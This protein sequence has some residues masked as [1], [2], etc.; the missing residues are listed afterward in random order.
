MRRQHQSG[1]W[2]ALGV[3]VALPVVASAQTSGIAGVVRDPSGGVLPGVT[4]TVASPALIEQSR[5]VVSD[6]QGLYRDEERKVADQAAC[7]LTDRYAHL[8]N[9]DAGGSGTRLMPR[10]AYRFA[11]GEQVTSNTGQPVRISQAYDFLAVA[12]RIGESNARAQDPGVD[13]ARGA[14][15]AQRQGRH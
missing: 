9:G 8:P 15:A 6:G 13:S 1:F 5:T 3:L 12:G 4:V 14:R 2:I 7:C 11:R 10:D